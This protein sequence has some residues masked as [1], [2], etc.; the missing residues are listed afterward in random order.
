[1]K[2]SIKIFWLAE[3]IVAISMILGIVPQSFA[4]LFL[5]VMLLGI[6]KLSS[7]DALRLYIFSIP[8]FVAMPANFLSESMSVWRFAVLFFVL[9]VFEEK[10]EILSIF[11]DGSGFSAKKSNLLLRLRAFFAEAKKSNYSHLIYPTL[12]L[13]AIGLLSLLFA[14]SPGAGVKR[15]IF[16]A[17]GFALFSIAYF[18]V[19]KKDDAMNV[20]KAVLVSGTGIMAVGYAQ[21][22]STFF[23][24]LYDF[25]GLWNNYVV[26]AFYGE[27]TMVL[28]SY[29]NTWFSYYDDTGDIPPTLRMFSVMPDSHSFSILMI[30]FAPLALFYAF[31]SKSTKSKRIYTVLFLLMMLAIF[32]SGSRGTWVGWLGALF[33]VCYFSLRM[34]KKL[35]TGG[36][37]TAVI[38]KNVKIHKAV[39]VAILSFILLF[40][41]SSFFLRENQD[42][43]LIRAGREVTGDR[44]NALLH[45]TLSISDMDETSNKGRME[46]WRDSLSSFAAH[47]VA[48]IGMGNFPLALSEKV[49][50]SKMGAS[51]HNIYLEM[52]VE[53]GIIGLM[54]FVLLNVRILER[55]FEL[56][57]RFHDENLRF[58]AFSLLVFFFWILAYGFFDVV[59]FNDKVLMFL[60]IVFAV[61]YRLES[62]ENEEKKP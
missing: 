44:R 34:P 48:G 3:F 19:K 33:A 36:S 61:V 37:N 58:L 18:A 25:W 31:K 50:T 9:K 30:I 14:E 40:P 46:I 10:F 28:L 57:Y 49:S 59:I 35:K 45:R 38:N 21:F 43:Q 15:I 39:L 55:F 13:G 4:Y 12:F 27:R 47:P 2:N 51:A 6:W 54:L 29:S 11:K 56:A 32:F 8:I 16:L 24:N 62:L 41:V 5:V 22:V 52:A 17:S 42:S 60:A 23:V 20:L 1:M 53:L 7:L 26:R